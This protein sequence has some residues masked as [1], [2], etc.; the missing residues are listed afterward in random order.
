MLRN[1]VLHFSDQRNAINTFSM[2]MPWY[3]LIY[4]GDAPNISAGFT[5]DQSRYPSSH[6]IMIFLY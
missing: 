4:G 5:F 3:P 1:D 2:E 6:M